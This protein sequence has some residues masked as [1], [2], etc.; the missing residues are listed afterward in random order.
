MNTVQLRASL[1][2]HRRRYSAA[3]GALAKARKAA[4]AGSGVVT[5]AEARKIRQLE[6]RVRAELLILDRR[7]QQL[8]TAGAKPR[9]VTASALGLSFQWVWGGKGPVVQGA[10]HYSAGPRAKDAQTLKDEMRKDHAFHAGKGWG[11]LSYEY[12]I[13]DDGT[14]GL[15]NPVGRKSAAVALHNT[16]TINVCCPATTG[17]QPTPAQAATLRWLLA[18]AHTRKLPAAHRAPVDLRTIRWRGH[19]QFPDQSTACP[20]NFLTL[21]DTKGQAR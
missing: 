21:Y 16:G 14:L 7:N 6:G 3:R 11:G 2:L 15:G 10:G 4:H 8:L 9:L 5:A 1:A 12:M 17:D 13:A 20:G 18:N 19:K